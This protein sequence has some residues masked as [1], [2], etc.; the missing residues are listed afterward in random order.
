MSGSV[1][2]L[3]DLES[4]TRNICSR[5]SV[6]STMYPMKQRRIL[7]LKGHDI[8]R[9]VPL[10]AEYVP[11]LVYVRH[12]ANEKSRHAYGCDSWNRN[13]S[14]RWRKSHSPPDDGLYVGHSWTAT[15]FVTAS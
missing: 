3:D 6:K 2:G 11:A 9:K 7:G 8:S 4:V 15:R 10:Y 13:D 1:S 5:I 12:E 14:D